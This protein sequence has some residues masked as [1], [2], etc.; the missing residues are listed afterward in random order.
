MSAGDPAAPP[1]VLFLC[2]ANSARSQMA[3]AITRHLAGDRLCVQSAGSRPS[4]V[5]PLSVQVLEEAGIDASGLRSKSVGEIDPATV[6][7]VITLCAEEECPVFFGGTVRLHW[8][9]PDPAAGAGSAEER[10]ASFRAVRDSLTARIRAWLA[11][12]GISGDS[13]PRSV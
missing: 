13:G 5:H 1:G 2:V 9:H 10:L 3:Q 11:E 7:I 6:E 12:R 4:C 8:E